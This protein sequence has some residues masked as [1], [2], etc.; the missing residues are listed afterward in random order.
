MAS[1]GKSYRV[2]LTEHETGAC[3]LQQHDHSAMQSNAV[4]TEVPA[5]STRQRLEF[6]H[7]I[8]FGHLNEIDK[9]VA[10]NSNHQSLLFTRA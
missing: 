8:F 1:G 9:V 2:T 6:W 7:A 3:Y 5:S 10:A 4:S